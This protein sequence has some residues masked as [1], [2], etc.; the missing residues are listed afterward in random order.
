MESMD[1]NQIQ[2]VL[3]QKFP[4]LYVDRVLELDV[5][6]GRIVCLK[7][8]TMNEHFF[9]GH[10][11]GNPIMPGVIMIEA[12]AQSAIILF[13]ATKPELAAKNPDYY[14][15]KV[16]IKFTRLVKPGDQFVIEVIKEKI[17]AGA[18]IVSVTAKVGDEIAAQGKIMFGVKANG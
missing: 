6:A 4:F 10:F 14:L 17:M 7:N 13:A 15:G 9:Q 18:G 3:P 12:M 1:I 11:P 8:L 2:K 5:S 16:D